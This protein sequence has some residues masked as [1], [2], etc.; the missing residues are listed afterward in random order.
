MAFEVTSKKSGTKYYLHGRT[1]P[2][3]SGHR[4]L[5]FFSKEVKADALDELP[6]GYEVTESSATGLPLLK[7]KDKA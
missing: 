4:T 7:R 3:K 5:Y 6:E 1:T 2:T